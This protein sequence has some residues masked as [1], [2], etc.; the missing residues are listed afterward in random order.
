[1]SSNARDQYLVSIE[2]EGILVKVGYVGLGKWELDEESRG[3]EHWDVNRMRGGRIKIGNAMPASSDETGEEWSMCS[4][5][6]IIYN[7]LHH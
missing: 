4:E 3:C 7:I 2:A 6:T 1:M 5:L